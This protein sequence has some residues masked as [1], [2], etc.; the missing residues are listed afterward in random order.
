MLSDHDVVVQVK[1]C[2][3]SRVDTKVVTTNEP[4]LTYMAGCHNYNHSYFLQ[5]LSQL[6]IST[7]QVPVGSEISG[8]VTKGI[9][10]GLQV[11]WTCFQS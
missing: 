6:G 7:E 1:A 2:A 3:L 10:M 4:H 8:I 9:V 11:I 5:L